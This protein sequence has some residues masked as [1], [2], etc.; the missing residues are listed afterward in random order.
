MTDSAK[1]IQ[2]QVET[3]AS[4]N[5]Q[6][7][8]PTKGLFIG[9]LASNTT[10]RDLQVL[11]G[12]VGKVTAV[13][14]KRGRHGD[15]L[16]HGFVEFDSESSAYSAIQSL[17]GL[18]FKGRKMRVNWTNTK[19]SPNPEADSWAQVQVNFVA[20]NP[21]AQ[22]NEELIESIFSQFGEIADVLVK[23]QIL[24]SEPV[25]LSGYGFVF[26]HEVSSAMKAVSII[27]GLV[28]DGIFFECALGAQKKEEKD[29]K[30]ANATQNKVQVKSGDVARLGTTQGQQQGFFQHP[31]QQHYNHPAQNGH[32]QPQQ[33]S[34]QCPQPHSAYLARQHQM[35]H[36]AHYQHHR[37]SLYLSGNGDAHYHAPH[38]SRGQ[39]PSAYGRSESYF[40]GIHQP[41]SSHPNRFSPAQSVHK[42]HDRSLPLPADS[43]IYPPGPPS[44]YPGSSTSFPDQLL[45][46]NRGEDFLSHHSREQFV[47]RPRTMSDQMFARAPPTHYPSQHSHHHYAQ[48]SQPP[49]ETPS[50]ANSSHKTMGSRDLFAS[51][52]SAGFNGSSSFFGYD[53][54]S[55]ASASLFNHQKDSRAFDGPFAHDATNMSACTSVA[56]HSRTSPSIL[57]DNGFNNASAYAA[58]SSLTESVFPSLSLPNHHESSLLTGNHLQST[59]RN[60]SFFDLDMMN[61]RRLLTEDEDTFDKNLPRSLSGERFEATPR[62]RV[63]KGMLSSAPICAASSSSSLSATS[64]NDLWTLGGF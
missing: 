16:L 18:K 47:H 63:L 2:N 48:A 35:T 44:A 41:Y 51:Q 25:Q 21:A 53:L 7:G 4:I 8:Q 33:Q 15:S 22:V 19:V 60:A 27:K 42:M 45:L 29:K 40:N 14:V 32:H 46:Q 54:P 26:F 62:D 38:P 50:P 34:Q 9:D 17:S 5:Q 30:P 43:A 52:Y 49:F 58:S 1:M 59:S 39:M 61:V 23:R 13:E 20:K 57:S 56:T 12:A 24:S 10:E 11:F 64:S 3:P 55:P 6:A 36:S 37:P 28:I 31:Q